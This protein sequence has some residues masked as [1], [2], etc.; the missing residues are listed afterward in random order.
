MSIPAVDALGSVRL[1]LGRATTSDV[2]DRAA[3]AVVRTWR[4]LHDNL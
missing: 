3:K 2:V 1:T 4:R